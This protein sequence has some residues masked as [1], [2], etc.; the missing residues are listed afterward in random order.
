[1]TWWR[2]AL[3]LALFLAGCSTAETPI[4]TA[5]PAPSA[6]VRP[7]PTPTADPEIAAVLALLA[8]RDAAWRTKNV[9]AAVA[10]TAADAPAAFRSRERALAEIAAAGVL[11]AP[12]RRSFVSFDTVAGLRVVQ[13]V[14]RDSQGRSRRLRYFLTGLGEAARLTEP[15]L[16]ALGEEIVVPGARFVT[17]FRPLDAEQAATALGYAEDALVSLIAVLGEPY[18]PTVA[19]TLAFAPSVV[20]DLPPLASAYTIKTEVTFLSSQSSIAGGDDAGPWS[21]TVV[22]HELAHVLLFARGNGPFVLSEGL[23][24]WLTDDRRQPE[25]DRIAA[26][27]S[28]WTLEHLIAGPK[29]AT[30]FFAGYAQASSFVRYLA[31]T[32]GAAKVVAAWEAGRDRPFAEAFSAGLGITAEAAYGAWRES[33]RRR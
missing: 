9:D 11:L 28:F 30:E 23:P 10:L 6:V 33:V 17:R 24:L 5:P 25:L 31:A 3:V 26:A 14:E 18:R 19:T 29:D 2:A 21:K 13:V 12:D 8:R 16:T 27:G 4:A 7:L 1:M 20:P 22:S 15:A 32:H